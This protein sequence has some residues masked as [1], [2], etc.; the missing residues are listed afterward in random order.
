MINKIRGSFR[1]NKDEILSLLSFSAPQF[2]YGRKRFSDIPVFCFHS[3]DPATFEK[4]LEFIRDNK[5]ITLDGDEYLER[6]SDKKYKN[7]GKEILLT[8]DDGM[9]SVWTAGL[10]LLEKYKKKIML[11]ILPGMMSAEEGVGATLFDEGSKKDH[12]D[13][14]NRDYSDNPLCNWS[15]IE[16]MHQSGRV[17]IQSHG[18]HHMLISTSS[19]I[20]DFIHPGFDAHHYGNIHIPGYIDA[21][22]SGRLVRNKVS[23]HPVYRHSPR[24][25]G[26]P[27]YIDQEEVRIACAE[28][29]RENGG[30][31]YFEQASWREQLHSVASKSIPVIDE[32]ESGEEIARE[33]RYELEESKKIIE[34]RLSGKT[35]RHFCYPWFSACM[36]SVTLAHEAGYEAVHLGASAGFKPAEKYDNPVLVTRLQE[37]Y[38]RALPGFG[39]YSLLKVLASKISR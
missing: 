26:K 1:K 2:V 36:E 13:I 3:V 7:N 22:M 30:D 9:S 19:Y 33:M 23:G 20:E 10:P 6:K 32:Y 18:M 27:R 25:S 31:Q 16:V 17:D 24:L 8:F 14:I 11:F 38:L 37:E 28:Y 15:E 4:H 5:F 34:D 29:V 12:D 39:S 21:A 35:V